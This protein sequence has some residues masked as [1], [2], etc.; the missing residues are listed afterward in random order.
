MDPVIVISPFRETATRSRAEH[1]AHAKKLC[2]LAC[3][4][5]YAAFASHVFYPLFLDENSADD[6][7]LGL[8]CEHAWITSCQE[9]W[10]WDSWGIS[11][12]M[13]EAIDFAHTWG[14][15]TCYFSHGEI[16]AWKDV[17]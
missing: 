15:P 3:R 13:R 9:L 16:P 1:L 10:I 12:G 14:I 5:G 8:A 17:K 6:R 2:E 7:A 11:D 4:A